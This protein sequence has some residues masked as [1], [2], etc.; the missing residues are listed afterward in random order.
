[1]N[2]DI[3]RQLTETKENLLRK[4]LEMFMKLLAAV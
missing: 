3:N 1:M 2:E 4:Y